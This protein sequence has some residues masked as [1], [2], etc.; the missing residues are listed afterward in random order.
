MA[1]G[2]P[3]RPTRLTPPPGAALLAEATR[4]L[5]G[6]LD[7]DRLM[8]RL[9]EL[10]RANLV[11]HMT[12]PVR[13]LDLVERIAAERPTVL[14]EVGP[15]QTLTRL[16]QRILGQRGECIA[17]D[18]P[19]RPGTEQLLA[20]QALLECVGALPLPAAGGSRP[21][22]TQTT[23]KESTMIHE[24]VEFDATAKRRDKMRAGGKVQPAAPAAAKPPTEQAAAPAPPAAAPPA[25]AALP[26]QP[27][28]VS[29]IPASGLALNPPVM[30]EKPA[31]KLA[32]ADLE[33]RDGD[34]GAVDPHVAVADELAR[35]RARGGEA[36]AVDG[37]VEAHLEQHQ[38]VLAGDPLAPVGL[39]EVAAELALEHAVDALDLLLLAELQAVAQRAAGA[40]AAV[41]AGRVAAALDR[42]LLL[43]AAVALEEELHPLAPA[44]PAD[45]TRVSCH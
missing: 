33:R 24:I 5:G 21:A 42:A 38:E 8:A 39:L 15:Q 20:V 41:L 40:P 22:S 27:A 9:T 2:T 1:S 23:K 19:K 7:L 14:V 30:A 45:G 44:Q 35:L 26:L 3:R 43:E 28:P 31:S 17:S 36:E 32:G 12:T 34:L 18:N 37:V 13:Y 11:A 6:T 10:V 16:H 4:A 29:A 25:A